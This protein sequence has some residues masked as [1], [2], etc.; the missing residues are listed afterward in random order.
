M[1]TTE[2]VDTMSELARINDDL[3]AANEG[4]HAQ[5]RDLQARNGQIT[6]R[7]R[8]L[9]DLVETVKKFAEDMIADNNE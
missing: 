7:L 9:Q 3:R 5:I 6:N 1:E 4:L 2:T 8:D